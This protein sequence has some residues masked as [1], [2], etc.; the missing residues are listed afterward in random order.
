MAKKKKQQKKIKRQDPLKVIKRI[1][2]ELKGTDLDLCEFFNINNDEAISEKEKINFIYESW[3]DIC[4]RHDIMRVLYPNY[5][6]GTIFEWMWCPKCKMVTVHNGVKDKSGDKINIDM[7]NFGYCPK[8]GSKTEYKAEK[9][10]YQD[11]YL[12]RLRD[13]VIM[14]NKD[15]RLQYMW[16][17]LELKD[18]AKKIDK[19]LD[20]KIKDNLKKYN[21]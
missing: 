10:M 21:K 8:C 20:K 14:P 1:I 3:D 19:K 2:D 9:N 16:Q 7:D 12:H 15:E 11:V 18:E 17:T 4:F 13:T 6:I 5:P